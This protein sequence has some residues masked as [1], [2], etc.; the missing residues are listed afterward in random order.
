MKPLNLDGTCNVHTGYSLHLKGVS[1]LY[2]FNL[3]Y[4][5]NSF[6]LFIYSKKKLILIYTFPAIESH[7]DNTQI[8]NNFITKTQWEGAYQD[9]LE[10]FNVRY[11]GAINLVKASNPVLEYNH[12]GGCERVGFAVLGESCSAPGKF[13]GNVAHSCLLGVAN[14]NEPLTSKLQIYLVSI[15]LL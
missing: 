4:C 15:R 1:G 12:V 14:I 8:R 2:S 3:V 7:G 6:A 11:N 5:S 9:R 13:V 10:T